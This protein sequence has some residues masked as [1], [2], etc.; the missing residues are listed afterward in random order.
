MIGVLTSEQKR[1]VVREFFELFKT[2]WEFYRSDGKYEVLICSDIP[3]PNNSVKVVFV[4]GTH[5]ESFDQRNMIESTPVSPES[6]L[7][8]KGDQV[9]IYGDCLLFEGDSHSNLFLH[10][11]TQRSALLAISSNGQLFVRIGF[12]LFEEIRHLLTLGQPGT[13]A[14]IPTLELHI[15]ILRDLI[16]CGGIT[17]IEIPPVPAGASF[18]ACLTH[19]VDHAG[20]RNHKFDHTM[21]GFLYRAF[22]GSLVALCQG[23]RSCREVVTNWMAALALPFVYF[24]W[25]KDFWSQFDR[26]TEIERDI[27][28]T[29]FLIPRKGDAGLRKDGPAPK[30]RASGYEISQVASQVER[31]VSA[32]CEIGLHGIDAWRDETKAHE[33]LEEVRRVTGVSELGVRMHWLYFDDQA[34]ALLERAGFSYDST[35]GY[36]ETVGYRTGTTQAFKPIDLKR[37]LELPMH[38]MDTALLYPTYLN[39][40]PKEVSGVVAPLIN[41]AVRFGGALVVNWHDRSIAPERLWGEVYTGLIDDLKAKQ[42]W[43]ATANQAVSW[44]RKRRSAVIESVVISSGSANVK[45]SMD[46][47]DNLPGVRIRLYKG[48]DQVDSSFGRAQWESRNFVDVTCDRAGEFQLAI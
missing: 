12:D 38:I 35:L 39:V 23:R 27:K 32:R 18:I 46:P 10:S 30:K 8:Y 37:M 13:Q 45:V 22:I 16:L 36:N 42:A 14:R 26:Y 28:S 15:A 6:V 31:L 29:F 20:I 4:Y 5:Q 17:L 41:N 25:A 11:T 43:F 21:F 19:D 9:P 33:E 47:N 34:P 48:A 44:F 40:A 3:L 1:P 24:G 7:S 2:P